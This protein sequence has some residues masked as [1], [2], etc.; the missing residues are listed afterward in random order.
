MRGATAG[1]VLHRQREGHRRGSDKWLGGSV[2]GCSH[3]SSL[4]V[5]DTELAA[6]PALLA[7]PDFDRVV[8]ERGFLRQLEGAE[9]RPRF[10]HVDGLGMG[11]AGMGMPDHDFHRVRETGWQGDPIERCLPQD[12]L[13]GDR[14]AGLEQRAVED[15]VRP[16]RRRILVAT[17]AGDHVAEVGGRPRRDQECSPEVVTVLAHGERLGNRGDAARV[18]AADPQHLAAAR[19]GDLYG[20]IGD[21]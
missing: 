2:D 15:R 14:L 3:R 17:T 7:A 8:T 12:M 21:G 11:L 20:G 13:H 19:V 4:E 5:L 9:R 16:Q 18:G 6:L 1:E 10:V